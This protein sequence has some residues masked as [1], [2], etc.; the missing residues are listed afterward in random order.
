MAVLANCK[1]VDVFHYFEEICKIPHGSRN[2]KAISDYIR[3]WARGLGLEVIQDDVLNLIIK[4]PAT[5]GYEASSTVIIQGHTDMVCEKNADVEF[6]FTKDPL[7]IYVDGDYVKA[8]GT[9][10]GADNG[11]AVAMAMAILADKSLVHPA[12]EIVLTTVEE[13]G[14]DGA[15][16]IDAS[17]LK[18]TRFINI[19]S[20]EEGVFLSSCAGG[21]SVRIT[22]DLAYEALP[23][24][25]YVAYKLF[26]GG[27]KGGHSGMDIDKERGN[28]NR[29]LARVLDVVKTPYLLSCIDG[30]SKD[31]AIPRE[32]FAIV[33]VK[34]D[35]VEKLKQE[36]GEY[37]KLLVAELQHSDPG[38]FVKVEQTEAASQ[39]FTEDV[40]KR[41]VTLLLTV[42]FGVDHMSASLPGLVETSNNLG[43]VKIEDGV[44]KINCAVRSSV[45]SRKWAL[46]RRIAAIAEAFGAT[47]MLTEGYSGWS[48]SPHSELREIFKDVYKKKYGKDAQILAIHAGVE[49]GIFADK[50][51]GLDMISFGPNM[52]DVHTPDERVSISSTA[53]CYAFL[54]DVLAAMK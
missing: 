23:T 17:H 45:E 44:L 33:H 13:A 34:K 32:A 51:P 35:D 19:D 2:E 37:E 18:G 29:L 28:S 49:C 39:A 54:L 25:D 36:V 24:G 7:D 26:V 48:Y 8:R 15:K 47:Y 4:K 16:G 53:N 9:T 10:L 5:A 1:P 20:E 14:M 21:A 6:D 22:M 30:G 43:V 40:K 12:L 50:M 46:C 31:N 27:L 11:I 3:D 52:H 38:L 42:P 41:A